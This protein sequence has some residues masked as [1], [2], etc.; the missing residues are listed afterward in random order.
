MKFKKFIQELNE[1]YDYTHEWMQDS[2]DKN[3]YYFWRNKDRGYRVNLESSIVE[4]VNNM[5]DYTF[6][7]FD[8][9]IIKE[10][11]DLVLS[12]RLDE[13]NK[14]DNYDDIFEK[15]LIDEEDNSKYYFWRGENKGY[16]AIV[17]DD[18]KRL[19]KVVKVERLDGD[20]LE[21]S[22]MKEFKDYKVKRALNHKLNEIKDENI[23]AKKNI[24]G[25]WTEDKDQDGTFYYWKNEDEGY[26][27]LV[28]SNPLP[29][30]KS[31]ELVGN[32]YF[33]PRSLESITNKK[34][35]KV[36]DK[37]IGD[38]EWQFTI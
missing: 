32:E 19:P 24:F 21:P 6:S 18:G 23:E 15:W 33:E 31:F 17:E 25:L 38:K 29:E 1:S 10:S 27:A 35:K 36:L 13:L 16:L 4:N 20:Y 34:I 3:I 12:K 7:V 5:K 14:L 11:L 22:I 2:K 30:I 8:N 37:K 26:V 9:N 28:E